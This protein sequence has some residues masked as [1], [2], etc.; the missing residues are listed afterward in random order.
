PILEELAYRKLLIDKLGQYNKR[1]AII[2]SGVMFGLFHTNLHQFFYATIIGF[3]FAYIYTISG[4]VR[5]T[6]I[7][8]MTFNFIHGILPM[9]IVKNLDLDSLSAISES[10]VMNPEV[11]KQV[12]ELYT[13]P[14]FLGLLGY[15]LLIIGL[16]I[17]GLVLWIINHKK[18]KV[19]DSNSPL[20]IKEGKYIPFINVGMILFA[21]LTIAITVLEIILLNIK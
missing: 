11:Q 20:P 5:Y 14:A 18:I 3:L 6:M 4:R 7:L 13:N 8:H 21:V 15:G 19:D 10:D 12:F 1:Y 9:A 2:L 16:W 17:A